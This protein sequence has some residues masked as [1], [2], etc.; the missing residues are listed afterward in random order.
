M[1]RPL[2]DLIFPK[3][4]FTCDAVLFQGETEICT[5]CRHE[6]PLC[7][8]PNSKENLI[9]NTLKGRVSLLHADALL[10]FEKKN[11]TQHLIHE[12][13]YKKQQQISGF[14]GKWHA[15]KLRSYPWAAT[16]DIIIPVPLHAKRLKQRG[17][18]QVDD[19]AREISK[20]LGC[21][22]ENKL[23]KRNHYS[24]TQVFKNRSRRTEVIGHNFVLNTQK[25]YEGKHIALA[26]D[27]ITTGSTA[28]AC[29]LELSKIKDV[30]LSLLV[31]A[32][33]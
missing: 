11:K 29:F 16:I 8:W 5:R 27:L 25:K 23:L 30:K 10:Y 21:Q 33:A 2:I 14:L 15:A 1:L 12:L 24:R 3:I 26:D 7:D 19:Y 9:T 22:Y 4:C 18:N 13:K 28:E 20:A 32:V 6:L 17:F 31:M